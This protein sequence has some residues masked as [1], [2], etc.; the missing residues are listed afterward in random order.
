MDIIYKYMFFITLIVMQ[1]IVSIVGYFKTIKSGEVLSKHRY[2]MLS[3]LEI[4]SIVLMVLL[5]SIVNVKYFYKS[6]LATVFFLIYYFLIIL[7]QSR[8]IVTDNGFYF[9]GQYV[10]WSSILE[11]SIISSNKIELKR[12]TMIYTELKIREI[13]NQE[14]FLKIAY[15]NCNKK[16]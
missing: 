10:K 16:P 2:K 14:M 11:I 12:L 1:L 13:E 6:Y 8:I 4:I 3:K 5:F 9:R 15:R 7:T